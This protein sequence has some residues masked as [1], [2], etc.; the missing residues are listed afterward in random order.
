MAWRERLAASSSAKIAEFERF[1]EER[2]KPDLV[3][4]EEKRAGV[5]GQIDDYS[6]LAR[7][8]SLLDETGKTSFRTLVDLGCQ[9]Y[10]NAR[11]PDASRVFVN[12]GLG[13]HVELTHEE[14]LNFCSKKIESLNRRKD[15]LAE[16][17]L[18]IKVL[19]SL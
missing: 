9:F 18:S 10:A 16:N 4:V 7:N 19:R 8:I 5:A 14:A 12:V 15:Y 17:A 1:I 6:E 3:A 13:F 11:V 2:L